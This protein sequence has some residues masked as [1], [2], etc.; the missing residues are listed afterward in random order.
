MDDSKTRFSSKWDID[1]ILYQDEVELTVASEWRT[2]FT[3]MFDYSS[4][5]LD[6]VPAVFLTYKPDG[7]DEWHMQ[8]GNGIFP[9]IDSSKVYVGG[10]GG[11]YT[12]RFYL[13]NKDITA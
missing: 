7:D 2:N 5:G 1:Q 13:L 9:V 3:E 6:Y 8:G 10:I 12:I 4:L 11:D